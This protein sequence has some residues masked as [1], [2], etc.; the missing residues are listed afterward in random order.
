MLD[1]YSD[2]TQ[3]SAVF[4]SFEMLEMCELFE[5]RKSVTKQELEDKIMNLEI[6]LMYQR[7]VIIQK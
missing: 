7:S 6:N 5:F 1:V 3:Q 2:L 4:E